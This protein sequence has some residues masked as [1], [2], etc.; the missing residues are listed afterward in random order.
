[1]IPLANE[2]FQDKKRHSIYPVAAMLF[3]GQLSRMLL[4]LLLCQA[5][6]AHLHAVIWQAQLRLQRNCAIALMW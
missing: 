3:P 4:H 1:L 6:A 5:A 2:S